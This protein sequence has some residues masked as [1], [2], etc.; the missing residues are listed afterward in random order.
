MGDLFHEAVSD[1][2]IDQVFTVMART[3]WHTF[4]LLTKR[5]DRF[6]QYFAR[7]LPQS[8]SPLENVWLGVSVEDQETADERIPIL[9]RTPAAVRFVS[10]EPML[11][12]VDVERWIWRPGAYG[13]GTSSISKYDFDLTWVI[14]GGESGPRARPSHPD[15]VRS[16]R[17]QCR[18]AGVPFFFKGWGEWAPKRQLKPKPLCPAHWGT[19]TDNGEF[20]PL[21]TCWNGHDDDGQGEA[22]VYRLGRKRAGRLLDGRT[23]HEFPRGEK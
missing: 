4:Q 15:W 8:I 7:N 1:Q 23:W 17:D 10:I 5:A 16:V 6:P 12:P 2:F 22:M 13:A 19:I 14:A 3:H 9:L 18:A 20:F 11:G 21:T